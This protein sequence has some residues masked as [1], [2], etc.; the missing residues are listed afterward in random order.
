M[1]RNTYDPTVAIRMAVQ[2][3]K[4]ARRVAREYDQYGSSVQA[5]AHRSIARAFMRDAREID[6][7]LRMDPPEYP[8]LDA[9]RRN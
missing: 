7:A 1:I 4:A 2:R 6:N 8:G 5:A 9:L 3:A